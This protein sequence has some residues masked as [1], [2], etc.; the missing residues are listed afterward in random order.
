MG[1]LRT[2]HHISHLLVPR[3]CQL[4]FWEKPFCGG[5]KALPYNIAIGALPLHGLHG[6]RKLEHEIEK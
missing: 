1:C 4:L 6:W 2:L 5:T 3:K